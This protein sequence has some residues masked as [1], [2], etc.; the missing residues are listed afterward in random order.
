MLTPPYLLHLSG[1]KWIKAQV[2]DSMPQGA[3]P[4]LQRPIAR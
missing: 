2:I 4:T 3:Y 1:P